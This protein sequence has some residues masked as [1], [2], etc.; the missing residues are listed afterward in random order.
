MIRKEL[1]DQIPPDYP[2][3]IMFD[4]AEVKSV[5]EVIRACSPFRYY[6][7]NL[8]KK[9]ETFEKEFAKMVGVP[10]CVAVS[11]GTAALIVALRALGIGP[12]DEVIIPAHA[13]IAC[14]EAVVLCGATPIFV[15]IDE[16]LM[17]DPI[18]LENKITS[19][20]KV[21]M[22][23]HVE[24]AA[25]AMDRILAIARSSK[26][27]VL[28][29]CAQ[30]CGAKYGDRRVGSL[31]HIGAFSFQINKTITTGEGG[32]ITTSDPYLYKR[33]LR[34]HDHGTI[35][36]ERGRLVFADVDDTFVSENYRM[37]E[38]AGALGLA[39]LAKLDFIIDSMRKIKRAIQEGL[40]QLRHF[41]YRKI[42]DEKGETGRKLILIAETPVLAKGLTSKLVK[43]GFAAEIPYGG[44]PVY[45]QCQIKRM[46][47]WYGKELSKE[48][49]I[50]CPRTENLLSR[51]VMIGLNPKF[52]LVH[53]EKLIRAIKEFDLNPKG[54]DVQ[55]QLA[56]QKK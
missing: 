29:D 14:V 9:V 3:A 20:T 33:A 48:N 6:G 46:R 47:M 53:V 26:V 32:A 35:R 36:D 52:T 17:L 1:S 54:G 41:Q 22:P 23:V 18:D 27:Q 31:G 42:W 38:L 37:S 13:F 19:R 8:L 28:E 15:E 44:L 51:S 12:G 25:C 39:Q 55:E 4:E 56:I 7:P 24:G 50:R 11:S 40:G 5:V 2:G 21:I 30:A 45:E 34:A 43:L 10:Y 16:S 49:E